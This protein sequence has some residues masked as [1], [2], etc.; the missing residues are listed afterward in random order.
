MFMGAPFLGV[1]P[2]NFQA[3]LH[4]LIKDKRASAVLYRFNHPH[5]MFMHTAATTGIFG[6]ISFLLFAGFPG[7]LIWKTGVG[8]TFYSTALFLIW[9]AFLVQ[10]LTETV[11]VMYRPFQGYILLTGL[12]IGGLVSQSVSPCVT[13]TQPVAPIS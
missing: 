6:L 9:G 8:S 13:E 5:N 7:Y 10:G 3:E 1:G 12:L 11:P 2:N 4:A